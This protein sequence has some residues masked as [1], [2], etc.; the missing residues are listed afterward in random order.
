[1]A[2]E[3]FFEFFQRRGDGRVGA[4]GCFRQPAGCERTS[5]I[6]PLIDE[7]AEDVVEGLGAAAGAGRDGCAFFFDDF[8]D[9]SL[10]L[11]V[12]CFRHSSDTPVFHHAQVQSLQ[13]IWAENL[14]RPKP[15]VM[16]ARL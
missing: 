9:G 13:D 3:V 4:A 6:E 11:L 8:H 14:R 2:G 7:D 16:E 5:L 1:M 10:G 12:G 15:F